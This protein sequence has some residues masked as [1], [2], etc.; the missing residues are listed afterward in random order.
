MDDNNNG[1]SADGRNIGSTAERK[2]NLTGR[3]YNKGL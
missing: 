3:T 1:G 2:D